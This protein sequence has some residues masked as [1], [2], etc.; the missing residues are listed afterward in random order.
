MIIIIKLNIIIIF[1]NTIN[2]IH[3]KKY[4]ETQNSPF[5]GTEPSNFI[6]QQTNLSIN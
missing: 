1:F 4:M 2:I 6:P 3:N 5:D